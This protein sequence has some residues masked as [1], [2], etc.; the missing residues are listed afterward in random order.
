MV[1]FRFRLVA[2]LMWGVGWLVYLTGHPRI[3]G[4]LMIAGAVITVAGD[5]VDRVEHLVTRVRRNSEG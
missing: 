1:W 3:T 5:Q 2:V 4:W